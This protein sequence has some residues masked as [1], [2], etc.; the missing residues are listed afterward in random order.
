MA[1]ARSR[2]LKL[3]IVIAPAMSLCAQSPDY[4]SQIAPLLA[5]RCASC[6]N[7][8]KR[9]GGLS[10]ATYEDVLVG[11]R[12]GAVVRPGKSADSMLL[13]RVTGSVEPRMPLDDEPLGAAENA[14]LTKWIDAGARATP[15]SAP[16]KPKWEA[17]LSL[18]KPAVPA[19]VWPG[20]S[21]PIDRYAASYLSRRGMK[22][23]STVSDQVFLRRA[24]L[25]I[26][27]LLPEPKD[28]QA[29]LADKAV[30]K[31]QK[32]VATLLADSKKY[33]ENWISY[34][35][36]LLRN[37][38]GVVY[39]SET[40]QRKSISPWIYSSLETNKPFNKWIH[41]LLNPTDP[42]DPDGFLIGVNWRGT[43]SASQTPALQAAQNTAQIFLGVNLKCNS[44]H[45]S[46]ISKWKL[47]QAYALASYFSEEPKLQLYR[48]DV[49]Q[50]QY[51]EPGFLFPEL[52][53]APASPSLK[54]R[55]AA[56]A[57]TFLD[58]RNGRLARTL[59]N[60]IWERMVGRGL[61]E[62]PDEMDGEPWSPQL[63]DWL[64]ADFVEHGYD[65]KR[66]IGLIAESRT[67]QMPAVPKKG[68]PAEEYVFRGPEVRRLTAE[69]FADAVGAITGDWHVY[70]PSGNKPGVPSREWH[71]AANPLTRA[72]GRPIRDQVY[73]ERETQAT[74]LQA[75]ELVNGETLTHW[76][77]RGAKKM[78]GALPPDPAALVDR[79]WAQ[80]T[81]SMPFEVDV[82]GATKVWLVIKD[83][84]TYSPEKV[85]AIWADAELTGPAGSVK[86]ASLK[87]VDGGG[88]R[89]S[90]ETSGGVRVRTPS[91]LA[92]DFAGRGFTKLR[93]SMALE[94][95]DI[96]SEINPQVRFFVFDKE[97]NLERLTPVSAEAPLPDQPV[98]KTAPEIVDRLFR[99]ALGRA[100]TAEER[101]SAEAGLTVSGKVRAEALADLLWA[102]LM[103]PEFQL[104][105]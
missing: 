63:L 4:Q 34:W 29:F 10:L 2:L 90:M 27:G 89:E 13:K 24:W 98:L 59:V 1:H 3:L 22:E 26:W 31:R 47:K 95:K 14:V 6:H 42:S 15:K 20:W 76:L 66:L 93:G 48:C 88:L 49:A 23:I 85:E 69:Q 104:V 67:Y 87:P 80:K 72:L 62:N 12:N 40:A 92:Y 79:T 11:G 105:Y 94:N 50:D 54:D 53:R 45:D 64:A 32:L 7:S 86:L 96:T 21:N 35:N 51:A 46:F 65:L 83:M 33:T 58:P 8:T 19:P 82:T 70:Q 101:R 74:T 57:A 78:L 9:S 84:G 28:V 75:L 25:D 36:D 52:D 30:D 97:P 56:A 100:P 60:R 38:E 61:V 102:I 81:G 39:Y 44:C 71:V 43:V 5:K 77:T 103:K 17:L 91:L 73:S 55:H 16:A 18:T 68:E 41:Q 37:D 99:S